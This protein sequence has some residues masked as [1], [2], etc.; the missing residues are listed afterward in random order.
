MII[1]LFLGLFVAVF[2]RIKSMY[3]FLVSVLVLFLS[4]LVLILGGENLGSNLVMYAY[5][6]SIIGL[7]RYFLEIKNG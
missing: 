7:V 1:F 3:L 5:F 2:F 6:L 4:V